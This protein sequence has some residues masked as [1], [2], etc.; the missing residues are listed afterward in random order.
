MCMFDSDRILIKNARQSHLYC[1]PFFLH[2]QKRSQKIF[3]ERMTII[4]QLFLTTNTSGY[5]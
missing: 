4:L 5:I 3:L 2:G 1:D